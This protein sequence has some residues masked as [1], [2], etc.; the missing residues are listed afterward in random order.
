MPQSAKL[1]FFRTQMPAISHFSTLGYISLT[2]EYS[3]RLLRT[4]LA[5][6]KSFIKKMVSSA[7][8]VYRNS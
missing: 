2:F 3:L 8:V 6:F 5:E 7:Y 4:T 1:T